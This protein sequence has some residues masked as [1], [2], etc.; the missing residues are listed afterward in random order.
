MIYLD[1][2]ATTPVLKTI[3]KHLYINSKN[4]FGNPVSLHTIGQQ[5]GKELLYARKKIASFFQTEPEYI[6]FTS[7][8]AEANNIILWGT[9]LY[10]KINNTGKNHIITSA[11]EHPSILEPSKILQKLGLNIDYLKCDRFCSINIEQLKEKIKPETFLISIMHSNNEIGTIQDIQK[12]REIILSRDDILIH[13]DIAQSVGKVYI[14]FKKLN[15]DVV[16]VTAHKFF[17]PKGIGALVFYKKPGFIPVIAGG[18]QELGLRAGT[19]NVSGIIGFKMA[20][21]YIEKNLEKIEKNLRKKFEFLYNE[22]SKIKNIVI[23]TPYTNNINNTINFSMVG[24]TKDQLLLKL[25]NEGICVSTG[26]ACMSGTSR[27][28]HVIEELGVAEEIKRGA[29]RISFSHLTKYQELKY[30]LSIIKN[31]SASSP[32]VY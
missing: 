9:F 5:A 27:I 31:L 4:N 3:A 32:L 6:I 26:T 28:S 20:I 19:H 22:L 17:G 11:V 12:I 30:F 21:E 23:N 2:N 18:I 14:D 13:S 8:G 29:I 10:H 15:V 25:D 1:Y 16:T 7:S 24:Y